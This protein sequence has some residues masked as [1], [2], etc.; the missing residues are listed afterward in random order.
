VGGSNDIGVAANVFSI[1]EL[2]KW[3]VKGQVVARVAARE[4]GKT[5]L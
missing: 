2:L 1:L 4:S 5:F 3:A